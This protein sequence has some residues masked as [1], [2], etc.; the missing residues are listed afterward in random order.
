M[1]EEEKQIDVTNGITKTKMGCLTSKGDHT[2][3]Q[4]ARICFS[5]CAEATVLVS[6]S[7]HQADPEANISGN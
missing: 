6:L 4:E 7:L 1:R 2:L 5:V 3:E